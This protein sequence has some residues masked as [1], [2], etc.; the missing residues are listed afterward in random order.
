MKIISIN[1]NGIRAAARKGFFDW[2]QSIDP[3][4]VCI[5]ETKAQEHQLT[6]PMYCPQGFHCYYFDAEKKGYS[7]VALYSRKPPKQVITGL[8]WQVADTEGRYLQAD[9][10]NLTV[11]SLYLPSGSSGE[12]RQT[13]KYDFLSRFKAHLKGTW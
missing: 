12:H 8:G 11:V 10:D 6:D 2:L 4:I 5:Q 3:D 9:F 7:G 13:I 1:T